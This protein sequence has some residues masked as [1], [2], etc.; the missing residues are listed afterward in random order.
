MLLCKL[1]DNLKQAVIV[2]AKL[3]GKEGDLA[4]YFPS[5]SSMVSGCFVWSESLEGSDFWIDIHA[6]LLAVPLGSSVTLK[7]LEVPYM[8]YTPTPRIRRRFIE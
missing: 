4:V 3:Q 8:D 5:I 7:D 2:N 1:P 6:Q